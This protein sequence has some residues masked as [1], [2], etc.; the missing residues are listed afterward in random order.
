[1][2]VVVEDEEGNMAQVVSPKAVA[3]TIPPGISV[4][5]MD[6]ENKQETK[7]EAKSGADEAKEKEGD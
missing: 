5:A 4:A 7:E 2:A 6:E 1:M 3:Q